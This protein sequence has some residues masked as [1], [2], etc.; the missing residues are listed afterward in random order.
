MT[1]SRRSLKTRTFSA[2]LWTLGLGLASTV[3]RFGNS[4]IITRLLVPEVFGV[5]ALAGVFFVVIS[6]LS[7]IGLK[8]CVIYDDRGEEQAFLNTVWGMSALRGAL[9]ALAGSLIALGLYICDRNGIIS[10]HSV[11]AHPD[12]PGVLALMTLSAVILG[13]KSPKLYVCE[14]RLDIKTIGYVELAAQTTGVVVSILLALQWRSVWCIVAGT[15]AEGIVAMLLSHFWVRGPIGRLA[16][17]REICIRVLR[18]GQWILYSS[19]AFVLASNA[20]R[21]LLGKWIDSASLGF[22]M[23]ALNIVMAA[24]VILSRPFNTVAMPVFREVLRERSADIRKVFLR[25]R[26]PFDLAACLAAGMLFSLGNTL[27]DLLYDP[28]YAS[29]GGTL[30]ILSFSLLFPRLG[31]IATAHAAHGRPDTNSWTS[32][33]KLI[34]ILVCVPVAHAIWGYEG[35]LWAI[36]FH[37]VPPTAFLFW[38]NQQF[39]LNDLWYELR[40]LLAWP[41]GALLGWICSLVAGDLFHL[42]RLH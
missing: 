28:R 2:G 31:V 37:M 8:Q 14:K 19:L 20:D 11:Y 41:V 26:L 12:L 1:I 22:Y 10:G 15:F 25:F 7:D 4:L 33:I 24:D 18:Y 35:A 39:G 13:L 40:V 27:I 30:K 36:V 17:D 38:R 23:L 16:L 3:I 6:L 29:A 34:S 32:L 21:L 5:V 9:I 42:V